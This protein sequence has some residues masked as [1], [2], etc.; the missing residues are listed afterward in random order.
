MAKETSRSDEWAA[1]AVAPHYL[2]ARKGEQRRK[3]TLRCFSCRFSWQ[4]SFN[5]SQ[6]LGAD[7]GEVRMDGGASPSLLLPLARGV[8]RGLKWGRR[9]SGLRWQ[10]GEN[11]YTILKEVKTPQR[12]LIVWRSWNLKS[13]YF[14]STT[15]IAQRKKKIY[16]Y[17]KILQSRITII[18]LTTT[19]SLWKPKSS[20]SSSKISPRDSEHPQLWILFFP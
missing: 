8:E 14:S 16:I 11:G 17:S 6:R 9:R 5:G 2:A 20:P 13:N 3:K 15:Q 18:L 19:I 1:A 12:I 4:E 10:R 7:P